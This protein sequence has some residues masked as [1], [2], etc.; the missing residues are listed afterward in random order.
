MGAGCSGSRTGGVPLGGLRSHRTPGH[1]CQESHLRSSLQQRTGFL[2]DEYIIFNGSVPGDEALLLTAAFTPLPSPPPPAVGRS[3]GRCHQQTAPSSVLTANA[4]YIRRHDPSNV[5]R[6]KPGSVFLL[7]NHVCPRGQARLAA[8]SRKWTRRSSASQ[9]FA[10]PTL[11]YFQTFR[12][13]A[14]C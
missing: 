6:N 9:R 11:G 1:R 2:L 13:S 8:S 7:R 10:A 12:M 14:A 3:V 4:D 5:Q